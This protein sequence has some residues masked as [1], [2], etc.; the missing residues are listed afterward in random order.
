MG[1]CAHGSYWGRTNG[2]IIIMSCNLEYGYT[3]VKDCVTFFHFIIEQ[4][5]SLIVYEY[6]RVSYLASE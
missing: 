6:T 5:A 1:G 4:A 3:R 2:A